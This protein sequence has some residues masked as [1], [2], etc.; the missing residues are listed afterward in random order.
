VTSAA[1]DP[2]SA[3]TPSSRTGRRPVNFPSASE[4]AC[5]ITEASELGEASVTPCVSV[6]KGA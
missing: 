1:K 4:A 5:K 3:R 2:N 6:M